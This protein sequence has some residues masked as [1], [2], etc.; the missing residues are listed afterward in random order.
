MN[1]VFL[2]LFSFALIAGCS[3]DTVKGGEAAGTNGAKKVF[4]YNQIN[5][6]TSLDPAFARS[7]NNIWGVDH[8]FNGLV[9]LDEQ[10]NI[11]SSIAKSWDISEDGKTY[12]FQLRDDVFF[13][14]HEIFDAGKGRKVIAQDVVN[15]FNRII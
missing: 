2:L 12:T 6:I 7:Q 5:S 8:L 9:R 1:K 15:S 4:S 10:L 14:D 13:H 3:S 11:K